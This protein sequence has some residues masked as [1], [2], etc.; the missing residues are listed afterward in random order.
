[1][2]FPYK[3]FARGAF[4]PDIRPII[5]IKVSHNDQSIRQEV[6]VDSGADLCLFDA[7]IGELLGIP[8]T[9]G[10]EKHLFG[11]TSANP[12]PFYFHT[13]TINVGG[14]D[15]T[16]EAGFVPNFTPTYVYALENIGVDT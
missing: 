9:K 8:V 5:P 13:V 6:L 12:Q 11:A 1:M 10:R 3:R 15:Y 2:K 16:I 4:P 14:W 7:Q